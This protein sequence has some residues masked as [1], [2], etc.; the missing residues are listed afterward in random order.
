M[1]RNNHKGDS[2]LIGFTVQL[3]QEMLKVSNENLVLDSSFIRQISSIKARTWS[4][5]KKKKLRSYL[6]LLPHK[7]VAH[8][9]IRLTAPA[10]SYS[11]FD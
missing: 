9:S 6:E 3:F 11:F 10:P 5:E 2:S 8:S 7:K 1:S 4:I